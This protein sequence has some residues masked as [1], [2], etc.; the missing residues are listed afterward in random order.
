MEELTPEDV[1][2]LDDIGPWSEI[3]L[4]VLED[5]ITAYGRIMGAE[6]QSFLT[7]V[8]VDAF[9][10][11]GLSVSRE[12]GDLVEGSPFR[13]LRSGAPFT[14]YHFIDL[15]RNRTEMLQRFVGD[16]P[17]IFF[18]TGDCNDVLLSHILPTLTHE[19]YRRAVCFLDPYAM[20][21]SWD[22]VATC[23]ELRTVDLILHFPIMAI[24]RQVLRKKKKDVTEKARDRMAR[25]WGDD[26]WE[27]IA[28]SGP[29]L[30]PE[31]EPHKVSNEAVVEAY[32]KR[33]RKVAGFKAV[34]AA[35]PLKNSTQAV[36]YYLILA[37]Q[38]DVARKIM[39]GIIRE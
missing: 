27:E 8:Y 7:P 30:F 26:S 9:S 14:E 16:R 15:D 24:N 32:R 22:V 1:A 5:Y 34:S 6:R 20:S 37:S 21:Y 3:K 33:L 2:D 12:T 4:K 38:K 31:Y 19:S 35:F 10:G 39:N 23:G 18:Y 17:N 28:Y 25:F 29:P 36:I 13:A 11:E